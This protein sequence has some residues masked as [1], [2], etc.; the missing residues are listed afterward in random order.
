MKKHLRLATAAFA[1]T[2]LIAAGCA[3]DDGADTETEETTEDPAMEEEDP[4]MEEEDPAMEEED[5]AA[6]EEEPA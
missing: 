3:E 1:A 6:E 4:A 5:P 2:A